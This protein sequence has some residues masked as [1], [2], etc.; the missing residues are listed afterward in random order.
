MYDRG[1]PR[2]GR[3][4]D[5][6]EKELPEPAPLEHGSAPTRLGELPI[7]EHILMVNDLDRVE[8]Y[9][10]AMHATIRPGDV[11]LE[12]GTGAGLLSCL[13]VHLGARH[14]YTV[15]RSAALYEVAKKVFA[16]NGISDKIT[17][18]HAKSADLV[19]LGVVRDPIDVFVTET[20]GAL[21]L[22]E[23]IVPIFEHV[24][25]LLSADTKVIPKNV[26]FKHCL[27]NLSGIRE[28]YEVV[29]R[30]VGIDLTAL[31]AELSSNLFYWLHPIESWREISSVAETRTYDLREFVLEESHQEMLI[32]KDNVCDGMLTWAEFGLTDEVTIETRYRHEG[33]SWA[34]PLYFMKRMMVGYRQTCASQ[35]RI[36]DDRVGWTLNWTIRPG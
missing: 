16:A 32:L 31:N 21:G 19:G 17:L 30:I 13:A 25:P 6:M 2:K 9:C 4:Y 22:N 15:E 7:L 5:T 35:F 27:V 20:I 8:T 1:P 14:V 11:V 33:N 34:N 23:G 18:V 26:K 10:S 29:D 36:A 3:P 28:R 24:K 12:V